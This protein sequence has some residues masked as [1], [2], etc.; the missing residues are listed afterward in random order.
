MKYLEVSGTYYDF[1]FQIGKYFKNYLN[2][3]IEPYREKIKLKKVTKYVDLLEN[4]LKKLFPNCLE[5]INGRADG[6]EIERKTMLLLFFPE[7][8]KNVDGCF[9]VAWKVMQVPSC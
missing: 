9:T 2:E 8:F 6:A 5:E 3:I 7:I 4:K 1:G